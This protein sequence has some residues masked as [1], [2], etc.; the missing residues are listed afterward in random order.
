M[1]VLWIDDENDSLTY[2]RGFFRSLGWEIT[3]A[4]HAELAIQLLQSTRFD[5]V[6]VDLILPANPY[7]LRRGMVNPE[8]GIEL[9]ARIRQEEKGWG[10]ASNVPLLIV[11]AV[12]TSDQREQVESHLGVRDEFISKPLL[13]DRFKACVRRMTSEQQAKRPG[14]GG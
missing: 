9:V 6:V 14:V 10:T 7:E 8:N 3:D 12:M 11:S 2:E 1:K 4:H 13:D 5:L